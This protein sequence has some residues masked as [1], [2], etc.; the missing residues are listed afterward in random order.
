LGLGLGLGLGRRCEQAEQ[1]LPEL[2]LEPSWEWE[3]MQKPELEQ[4][5]VQV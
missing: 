1:V 5:P 2:E 4:V 3:S